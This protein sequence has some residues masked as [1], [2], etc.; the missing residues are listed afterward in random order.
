M[1]GEACSAAWDCGLEKFH[2]GVGGGGGDARK[3]GEKGGGV[4]GTGRGGGG[5]GGRRGG[6][7]GG[8]KAGGGKLGQVLLGLKHPCTVALLCFTL[9]SPCN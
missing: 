2:R 5:G 3:R 7:E 6:G 1:V 8:S 4:P 9:K